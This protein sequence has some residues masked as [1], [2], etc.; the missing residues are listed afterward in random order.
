[1]ETTETTTRSRA[2]RSR[3]AVRTVMAGLAL[4]GALV[5]VPAMHPQDASAMR[6]SEGSARH[7]C[8]QGGGHITYD[9]ESGSFDDFSMYCDL[10]SGS[11]FTCMTGLGYIILKCN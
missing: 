11:S 9:F 5:V 8:F 1:M 6:M 2:A 10:P 3:S 4:A 7:A